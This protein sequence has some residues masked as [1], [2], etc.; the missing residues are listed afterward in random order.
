MKYTRT[1]LTAL[2][3]AP[4]VVSANDG[5]LRSAWINPP[6]EYRMNRNIH[7]FPLDPA[8]QDAEIQGTL[9]SGWGGYALNVPFHAYLTD[10]GMKA[11]KRFC[12][13]AKAKGMELWLYDEQGYPSGNAGDRVIREN[14]AWECMGIFFT[15][16]EVKGGAVSLEMPSGVVLLAV[17]FPVEN[18]IIDP[19]RPT[20]LT[21]FVK[22]SKL[23]WTAPAG[24]WR[25]FAVSKN[26]LYEGFQAADKGGGK[27]GSRYPSLLIPEV[28][29]AFLRFTHERYAE[30]M[31]QDLGKYF[32]ST[33]TDEPSLMA[34]QF[35]RYKHK[36][37]IVPWQEI[38]SVEMMKRHGFRPEEKLVVFYY[39]KGPAGQKLRYQYFKTVADLMA[40]NYFGQI[41]TW[42]E[43][44]NLKSGGHLLLEESMIAHVPLYG[45]IMQCFRAMHAPGV[46]ILS[47]VP[48]NMPMQ[49]LK[50]ASSAAQLEDNKLVM[51]EPCPVA[52]FG[53]YGG[54]EPPAEIVRGHLNMLLLGGVTDFNCYL[55]LQH[56]SPAEK[57]AMNT[58]IGRINMLL[59]NG[60]SQTGIG[61]V[62]PIESMW[63][64]FT[65]R[66]HRVAGWK[67]VTGA[68]PAV[69]RIDQ[70]FRDVSQFL[71]EKRWEY[72]HLDAQALMDA[73]VS[74]DGLAHGQFLFKTIILPC[75]DTLPAEA[76]ARL[77]AFAT[78][79]GKII[80]VGE[81]PLNSDVDFPDATV[82]DAF[83][84]HPNVTF[85]S[86]LSAPRLESLLLENMTKPVRLKDET[87][88]VRMTHRIVDGR[89]VFFVINDSKLPISVEATFECTGA[90]EAWDPE[91]GDIG[92]H[93]NPSAIALKPYHG[94]VYRQTR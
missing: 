82:R 53:S 52:D 18:S 49:S 90:M 91:T 60:R 12:D 83:A 45:S 27:L 64:K 94:K 72:L 38:V 89:N 62:Y 48:K 47:C 35:H 10:A 69:N 73:K 77:L 19:A 2:L 16:E 74:K 80:A 24:N 32:T 43:K 58:Y 56:S 84:R 7:D 88:P 1:L 5:D 78:A 26:V 29:Q 3:L 23:T 67:E 65:P 36:H 8:K 75:V 42:C 70:T 66:F 28:T 79:G 63:T 9:D 11:T 20:D 31:G 55:Q 25:V 92:S 87:L 4:V 17:A 86:D 57:T 50:L 22:D 76:W 59:H 33:F 44:H 81:M 68:T 15:E 93:A 54:K 46:D 51:A 34:L 39:D 14:P 71:F 40:A 85:M 6:L 61:V 41:K 21:T 37:A 13:A 30:S